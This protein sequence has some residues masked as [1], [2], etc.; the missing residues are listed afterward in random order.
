LTS[1][2][3]VAGASSA[4]RSGSRD[5][6]GRLLL[7]VGGL[8]VGLLLGEAALRIGLPDIRRHYVHAPNLRRQL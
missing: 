7:V 6:L 3:G 5:G 8:L 4:R 2:R 1:L